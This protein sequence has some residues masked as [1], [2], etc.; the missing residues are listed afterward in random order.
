M[1]L[2]TP[3]RCKYTKELKEKLTAWSLQV[4]EY[5]HQFKVIDEAQKTSGEGHD[6][7]GHETRLP[8]GTKEV[9]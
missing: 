7:E 5:E 2:A 3:K 8:D 1:V 4:A 6:V 9:R